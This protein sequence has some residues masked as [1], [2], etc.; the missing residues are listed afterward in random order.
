MDIRDAHA[1]LI[2][3]EWDERDEYANP[4]AKLTFWTKDLDLYGFR[5][6]HESLTFSRIKSKPGSASMLFPANEFYTAYFYGQHRNAARPISIDLPGVRSLYLVVD[7]GYVRQGRRQYIEVTCLDV[8]QLLAALRLWPMP[9]LPAELQPLHYW[10]G[11]GPAAS[12]CGAAVMANLVRVQAGLF[13]LPSLKNPFQSI[14]QLGDALWPCMV[15]PRNKFLRDTSTW[16]TTTWRMDEALGAVTEVCDTEN[17]QLTYQFYIPWLDDQPFPEIM[18]LNRPTVIFDFVEKGAPTGMTGTLIDGIIRTG[19]AL[20]G[21]GL[22][23]ITY[24][25]LADDTWRAYLD[26]A[27]G[28][29]GM[30]PNRPLALYTTGEYSP[31]SQFSQRSY[32]ATASRVTAGGKSPDWMNTLMV[33]GANLGLA[34]LG[35]AIGAPGVLQLGAFEGLVKDKVMAFHSQEDRRRA[36][37]GGAMRLRE[38]FA[39]SASTGL[40][41]N[42]AAGMKTAHWSTRDYETHAIEVTNGAPYYIGKHLIEGDPV[43]VELPGG[44]GDV[45]IDTL[46]QF[47]YEESRTAVGLKLYVGSPAPKEPGAA[48]LAKVRNTAQWLH[49]AALSQ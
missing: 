5:A 37:T 35:G 14:T 16:V 31:I 46:D 15:N 40:S 13:N 34:A 27:A 48:A 49:R 25:I 47:D 6:D 44:S 24:P 21:D 26:R 8:L 42:T 39:E 20:A 22:D 23:W 32:V 12:V 11:F 38:T 30:L 7:F 3:D 2:A 4:R 18:R 29:L 33:T 17:L 28:A 43:A 41:L 10:Y 9:W 45:A 36:E 1:R 19:I